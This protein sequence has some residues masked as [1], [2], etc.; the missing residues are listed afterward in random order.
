MWVMTRITNLRYARLQ[1]CA[2][3]GICNR[4]A[5][6]MKPP[7]RCVAASFSKL[8]I[9]SVLCRLPR[10]PIAEVKIFP[11][12]S[13]FIT[14]FLR[15]LRLIIHFAEWMFGIANCFTDDFQRFGHSL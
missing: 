11:D 8:E 2:T 6:K 9:F 13:A 1:I 14:V 4:P 7:R 15:F 5:P 12:F 10:H 3:R